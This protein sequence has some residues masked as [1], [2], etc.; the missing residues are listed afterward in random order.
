LKALAPFFA[1]VRGRF[2][3]ENA[4]LIASPSKRATLF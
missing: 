1:A 3:D 4:I 2:G